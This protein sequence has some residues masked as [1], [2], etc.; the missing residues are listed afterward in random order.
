VTPR[1]V[2]LFRRYPPRDVEVTVYGATQATY[3]R[4][5]RRPGSFAAFRGGLDLLVDRGVPV[6]LKAMVLRSNVHELDEIS[7]FCRQ[8]TKDF[9]RFDPFLHLRYD[10][11]REH[12]EAIRAERLAP[13]EIVAIERADRERFGA[14]V[15]QCEPLFRP[16]SPNAAGNRLFRCGAGVGTFTVGYDGTFR[17]CSSLCHP[18]TIYDLRAGT[19]AEAYRQVVPRVRGMDSDRP[20]FLE[21][22]GG[23]GLADLC[24]CCPAHA[25]LETGQMDGWVPYYCECARARADALRQEVSAKG[26]CSP[27]PD[28]PFR[29]PETA[30]ANPG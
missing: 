3:E 8:R 18:E 5:T 15:R 16:A 30:G 28:L 26:T 14:L 6:R 20:E 24:L 10:G 23:C 11:S 12:N 22:C 9:Y 1:H 29:S 27:H 13:A 19:L 25:A 7:R 17:L 4:V 2:E 21:H